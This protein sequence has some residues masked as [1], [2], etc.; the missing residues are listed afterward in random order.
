LQALKNLDRQPQ[1]DRRSSEEL[2]RYH[3]GRQGLQEPA[4]L[5]FF[6]F[7]FQTENSDRCSIRWKEPHVTQLHQSINLQPSYTEPKSGSNMNLP[8]YSPMG[9]A[10]RDWVIMV[11]DDVTARLAHNW[12]APPTRQ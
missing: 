5:N 12:L 3:E 8:L 9:R 4:A 7:H 1:A 2:R 6:G 11:G 10:R